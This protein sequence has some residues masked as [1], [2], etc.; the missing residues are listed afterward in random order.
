MRF[1]HTADL[2]LDYAQYGSALRKNDFYDCFRK[3]ADLAIKIEADA[4]VLAG[5]LLDTLRP[6]GESALVLKEVVSKLLK[7]KI[8]VMGIN[9][10]HDPS[11]AWLELCGIHDLNK[12]P[13][14][15][16]KVIFSGSKYLPPKAFIKMLETR[17][18]E[19]ADVFVCHQAFRELTKFSREPLAISEISHLIKNMGVQYV[20][21]GDIHKKGTFV[22]D[23]VTFSYSGSPE[24]KSTDDDDLKSINVVDINPEKPESLRITPVATPARMLVLLNIFTEQDVEEDKQFIEEYS[25]QSVIRI[26]YKPEFKDFVTY[27]EKTLIS[28]GHIV[29]TYPVGS[30][31]SSPTI[32][33]EMQKGDSG[34][35]LKSA[36]STYFPI[37]SDESQTIFRLLN[38]EDIKTV[39]ESFV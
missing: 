12:A 32:S 18:D 6:V 19:K 29:R 7:E 13:L 5:D 26:N 3:I 25:T 14:T 38:G 35:I 36:V 4:V 20:A 21:M 30:G 34:E 27:A 8:P 24:R 37:D 15:V 16:K 31:Y 39:V 28:R 10:N 33:I 2:H 17:K 23:G 11:G 22:S 1:V 9:G